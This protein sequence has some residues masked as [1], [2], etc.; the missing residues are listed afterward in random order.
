MH[1]LDEES[2][3]L[4]QFGLLPAFTHT[5]LDSIGLH[6]QT[7][8]KLNT[9]VG[10]SNYAGLNRS[11]P[12][13]TTIKTNLIYKIPFHIIQ[14]KNITN[15][16]KTKAS[17]KFKKS[18]SRTNYISFDYES[19]VNRSCKTALCASVAAF[20]NTITLSRKARTLKRELKPCKISLKK[21]SLAEI[22]GYKVIFY[23]FFY[24]KI[25][26]DSIL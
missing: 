20:E 19:F 8:L 17:A 22:S 1:N 2:H 6:K 4:S 25:K 14:A 12:T 23:I 16:I 7:K 5:K 24:K 15:L 21:L 11:E 9:Y 10:S 18:K 26:K 3:L 13:K